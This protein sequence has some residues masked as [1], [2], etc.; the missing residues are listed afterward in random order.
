MDRDMCCSHQYVQHNLNML[1]A[2]TSPTHS[3]KAKQ[4]AKFF[5]KLSTPLLGK[6]QMNDAH[7]IEENRFH[8][9]TSLLMSNASSI[10]LP[11]VLKEIRSEMPQEIKRLNSPCLS[12]LIIIISPSSPVVCRILPLPCI[13]LTVAP[14]LPSTSPN[15]RT[16]FS[17]CFTNLIFVF[18]IHT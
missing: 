12:T 10:V 4:K 14:F 1:S 11:V 6:G 15:S 5:S 13:Q 8:Q 18:P 2:P 7:C 16:K 17:C 3:H 9:H